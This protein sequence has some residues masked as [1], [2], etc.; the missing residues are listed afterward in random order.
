MPINDDPD[1]WSIVAIRTRSRSL[2]TRS[3]A[4]IET[5]WNDTN[6]ITPATCRN[7]HQ[8]YADRPSIRS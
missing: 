8:E 6:A 2:R 5:P 1:S 3:A 7:F 4:I